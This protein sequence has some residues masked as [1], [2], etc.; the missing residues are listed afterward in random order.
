MEGLR[1]TGSNRWPANTLQ[2]S[3]DY[4]IQTYG[5]QMAEKVLEEKQAEGVAVLLMNP[6]KRRNSCHGQCAGI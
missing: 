3:L 4:N 1:K 5:E 6:A 2:I